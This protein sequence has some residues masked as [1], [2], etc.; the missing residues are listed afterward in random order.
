M[1]ITWYGQSCFRMK[2]R[3]VSVVADPYAKAGGLKLPRLTSDIVTISHDHADHNYAEG[4]KGDPFVINSP[5]EY[6]VKGLFIT[7][8]AMWHDDK[9]GAERGRNT[10]YVYD[11]NDAKIC[12]LGDLGHAPTQAQVEEMGNI[13]VLLVPVGGKYTIDAR[14]AVEVVSLIEPSI[15]IPMHYALPGMD[16]PIEGVEAFLKEM[17]LRDP[18][19]LDNYS[20]TGKRFP[21]ETQVILLENRSS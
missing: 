12:H 8:L 10:I 11:F 17:G 18:E 5:G 6:E 20:V 9:Q 21:E 16:T 4:V 7:G 1:D 3:T 15:V 2:D 13:D 14:Q 19:R